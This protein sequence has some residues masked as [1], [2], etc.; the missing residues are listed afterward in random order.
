VV[1]GVAPATEIQD[2]SHVRHRPTRIALKLHRP[3]T[4]SDLG[5]AGVAVLFGNLYKTVLH[6]M[7][8][9]CRAFRIETALRILKRLRIE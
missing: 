5:C 1:D 2:A 7:N 6:P 4:G 3:Q 8:G 9:F